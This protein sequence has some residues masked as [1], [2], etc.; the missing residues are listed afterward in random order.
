MIQKQSYAA[1]N[2]AR[3]TLDNVPV[4][5]RDR[6]D[7]LFDTWSNV[8]TRNQTLRN[9]YEQHIKVKN[10]GISIPPQLEMVET[11]SGWCAKAVQT[12]AMRSIFDGY[13]F[14]GQSDT[15]LDGLVR[16]NRL[17]SLYQQAVSASLVYG[18][19][20]LTVMAGQGNQPTAKVRLFSANQACA[21]WDKDAD[22]IGCGVVLADVD[23]SGNPIRY[24]VHMPDCVLTLTKVESPG[25]NQWTCAKEN[26]PYGA[27][28]MVPIIHDPDPDRPLGHSMLTPELLGI[29]DKAMRDVL[30]MEIGAE[31][32]T[33][34]QRYILGAAD[35]LFAAP[36]G[37]GDEET[38]YDQDGN[39]IDAPAATAQADA[40]KLK[41][42]YGALW[43][44]T[45]DEDGELP[46]V[47]EFSAPGAANFTQ[48]F[49]NDAQRF[50]GATNVPLSQLGVLSNTYTSSDALGAANDPLILEVE[51][52]NRRNAEAMEDVAR[53][54]MCVSESTTVA[55]LG[56]KAWTVQA[57]M[58]DPSKST[59]AANADAWV[60]IGSTDESIVGTDVWYEGV[61]FSQPTIQRIEANK[62]QT[63]ATATLGVI[64]GLL[65][66]TDKQAE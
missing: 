10:L 6:I 33:A 28:L 11:V 59:F 65:A 18:V 5:Y 30:R 57:Y 64:A 20:F 45:R 63:D 53:M 47:G 26:N 8:K 62:Q 17:R 34:P 16:A 15:K 50:S 12:H 51:T 1:V 46:Q 41:A 44:I 3:P 66:P 48:V 39:E 55:K 43:A 24:V 36:D 49:E 31:F 38:Y 52:M 58:K 19:S 40:A 21:T 14:A 2:I 13:V 4:E 35:D 25:S 54:M 23:R 42:Y 7:D 22:R 9:Y 32:F 37:G 27:P 29:V 61:G 60:K 56:D